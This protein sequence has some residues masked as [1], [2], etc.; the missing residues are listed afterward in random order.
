MQGADYNKD[1]RLVRAKIVVGKS[2]RLFRRAC[3]GTGMKRWSSR[4]LVWEG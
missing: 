3:G 4:V 2:A 1:H